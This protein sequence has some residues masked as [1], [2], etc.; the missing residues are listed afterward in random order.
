M[1]P[2][3]ESTRRNFMVRTIIGIAVFIGAVLSVPFGGFGIL[4]ALRKKDIGWSD[5]GTVGDLKANEP[6]ERRFLQIVKSGWQEEKQERSIWIVKRPD[7]TITAY[8]PNCPHL[9][10]GYRWFASDQRFKCPCHGS[11]F[12]INGKVLAGPSPRPLDTLS[13][14]REDGRIFVQ[15]EIYQ[16]GIA[17]KVIA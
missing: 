17:K 12:D 1:M 5:A 9:G 4:P 7:D 14:K 3:Q 6:Q 11:V 13:V 8:A 10:C 15:Y 2:D 16:L